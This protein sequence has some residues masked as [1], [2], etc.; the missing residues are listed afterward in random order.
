MSRLEPLPFA[1]APSY[2]RFR[3]P[4][5][6]ADGRTSKT[7]RLINSS[8]SR[9]RVIRRS[10]HF[11]RKHARSEWKVFCWSRNQLYFCANKLTCECSNQ[12]KRPRFREVSLKCDRRN[13]ARDLC[14]SEIRTNAENTTLYSLTQTESIK[15]ASQK[16]MEIHSLFSRRITTITL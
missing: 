16:I 11:F 15:L 14:E 10:F 12:N 7:R 13:P 2:L 1:M 6:G 5:M 4:K 8:L 3:G 9:V